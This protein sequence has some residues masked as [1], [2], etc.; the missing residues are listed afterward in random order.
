MVLPNMYL[1][2]QILYVHAEKQDDQR[3]LDDLEENQVKT[4][5]KWLLHLLFFFLCLLNGSKTTCLCYNLPCS[6]V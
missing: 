6:D 5:L 2:F 3:L 4:Q 1:I